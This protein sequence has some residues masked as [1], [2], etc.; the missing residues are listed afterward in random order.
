MSRP[1]RQSRL[2]ARSVMTAGALACTAAAYAQPVWRSTCDNRQGTTFA[3]VIDTS[4]PTQNGYNIDPS[5][6]YRTFGALSFPA[7][8]SVTNS[9]AAANLN[10]DSRFFG[11][12][13]DI[14]TPGF[15]AIISG[16]ITA[17]RL[18]TA[19]PNSS[20]RSQDNTSVCLTLSGATTA[21][22][23]VRRVI[24]GLTLVGGSTGFVRFIQPNGTNI[25]NLT[26]NGSATNRVLRFTGNGE[27]RVQTGF[28]TTLVT[29]SSVTTLTRSAA[30]TFA[31]TCVGDFNGTGDN[32]TQDIFD[33][34]GAWFTGSTAA[35]TN[36]STT[37]TVQ[38]IFDFLAAWFAPCV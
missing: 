11:N 8:Q 26:T 30:T 25:I 29:T 16:N 2:L 20:A 21:T 5:E 14:S 9:N 1:A 22:P 31:L 10:V 37:I 33:F 13:P 12:N 3:D 17:R 19:A 34:L 35:D 7:S 36:G 32:T 27:Y 28:D 24:G 38:D 18:A 4:D 6:I 23:S 15:R